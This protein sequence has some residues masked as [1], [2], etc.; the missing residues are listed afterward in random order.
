MGVKALS[1]PLKPEG[2]NCPARL[3]KKAGM[4]LPMTPLINKYP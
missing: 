3:N 1:I 4:A 2:I